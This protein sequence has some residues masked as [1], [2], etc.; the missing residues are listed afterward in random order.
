M[1][2]PAALPWRYLRWF[3]RPSQRVLVPTPTVRDILARRGLANLSIW[4]RGVDPRKF[5]PAQRGF[6][7]PARPYS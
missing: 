5:S 3:H 2:I 1:G 4:S 7:G 6:R